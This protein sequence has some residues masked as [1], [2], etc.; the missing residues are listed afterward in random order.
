VEIV[1]KGD[2]AEILILSLLALAIAVY[3]ALRP[4]DRKRIEYSLSTERRRIVLAAI[5]LIAVLYLA[6]RYIQTANPSFQIL[7]GP[8]CLP[9]LFWVD[10]LQILAVG[11]VFYVGTLFRSRLLVG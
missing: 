3:Q 2:M 7:C 6:G 8:V 4:A 1:L 10:I 5:G 11:L 9:A